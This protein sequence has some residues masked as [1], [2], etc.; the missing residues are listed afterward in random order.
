VI[1]SYF[2]K[3]HQLALEALQKLGAEVVLSRRN[4]RSR[5]LITP[6]KSVDKHIA[7]L[8]RKR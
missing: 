8:R 7:V 4:E 3:E 5:K 2:D 6:G 1:T